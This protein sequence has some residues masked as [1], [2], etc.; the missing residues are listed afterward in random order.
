MWKISPFFYLG[1]IT[2]SL[3]SIN[4]VYGETIVSKYQF[5]D[6]KIR[7]LRPSKDSKGTVVNP[8]F[9][10]TNGG[11]L[12][13]TSTVPLISFRFQFTWPSS[14]SVIF[15]LAP[16]GHLMYRMSLFSVNMNTINTNNALNTEKKNTDWFLSSFRPAVSLSWIKEI[17]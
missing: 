8:R 11:L 14:V 7:I 6:G 1:N 15:S 13:I 5:S 16:Q 12:K 17:L 4:H 3:C 10:S 2:I 9:H